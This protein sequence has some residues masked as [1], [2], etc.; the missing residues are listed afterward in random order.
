MRKRAHARN[1]RMSAR[2]TAPPR[3]RPTRWVAC[4]F[5]VRAGEFVAIMGPSGCG[6]STLLNILG[7]LDSPDSGQYWFF[8]RR[9]GALQR[10]AA[11]QPAARWR[12]ASC[13]RASILW[14]TSTC[15]RTWR[16]RCV[17]RGMGGSERRGWPRAL[18]RVGLGASPST[19]RT[20]FDLLGVASPQ[21]HAAA[22][23]AVARSVEHEYPVTAAALEEA[24]LA[25]TS[26]GWSSPSRGCPRATGRAAGRQEA[27]RRRPG[28]L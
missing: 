12:R 6:K 24:P 8:G 28:R 18:E 23:R 15:A 27:C 16:C 5:E 26:L 14:T 17:Y 3:S 25:S 4:R 11:H 9:C 19:C 7:L 2:S 21:P 13:S 20:S 22:L 10:E 1:S